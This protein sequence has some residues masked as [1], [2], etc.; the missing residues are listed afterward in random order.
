MSIDESSSDLLSEGGA[1]A[2]C[3]FVIDNVRGI[4]AL[5]I[6][7][8]ALRVLTESEENELLH[9]IMKS[10]ETFI[11]LGLIVFVQ[12]FLN[13]NHIH[14]DEHIWIKESKRWLLLEIVTFYCMQINTII[15]LL[16]IQVRG[17][18]GFKD[19]EA[20]EDR[21]KHD[22]LDYY[23]QDIEWLSFQLVPIMVH[24]ITLARNEAHGHS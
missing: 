16:Y 3:S 20:N 24:S 13:H 14:K 18:F 23:E 2:K 22:A 4:H 1:W 17:I 15:F 10:L 12:F 5:L 11:Y 8:H 19:N 6:A 7:M 9:Q 21:F